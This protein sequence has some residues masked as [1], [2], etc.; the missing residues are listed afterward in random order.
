MHEVERLQKIVDTAVV[1]L[2]DFDTA[3]HRAA[4]A[5]EELGVE[6][7]RVWVIADF[8]GPAGGRHSM[9]DADTVI[10]HPSDKIADGFRI[11]AGK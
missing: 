7:Q 1:A 5:R 11:R 6:E 3:E 10:L 8:T 2:Q 4:V 9:G